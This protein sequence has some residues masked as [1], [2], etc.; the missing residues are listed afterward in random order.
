[1]P[2]SVL[3]VRVPPGREAEASQVVALIRT[4]WLTGHTTTS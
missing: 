2:V 1:M 3:H 4:R